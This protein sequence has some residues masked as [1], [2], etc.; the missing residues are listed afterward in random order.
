MKLKIFS[1]AAL[2]C[3]LHICA[4]AAVAKFGGRVVDAQTKNGLAGATVSIPDLH[5][6]VITNN[7]GEFKIANIKREGR[8]L[9]EVSYI[10][11]QTLT[12][13]IDLS[14]TTSIDFVLT[15]SILEG[16]E[17]VV[18]GT[19]FSSDIK[20]NSSSVAI[21]SRDEFTSK[22]ANNFIDALSGI[23][24]VSQITT[25]TAVSKPVIR[26]LS[27]NRVVT[28]ANGV[29]QEGSQF[30][31]EHGIEIDQYTPGRVELIRGPASLLYGSDALA[32]VINLV[33]PVQVPDEEGRMHGEF[34]TN[35]NTNNG[36]WG[37]SLMFLE[38]QNGFIYRAGGT[39][40][41]A[42]SFKTPT[43][44]Y[45]NSGSNE[46]NFD[47]QAGVN[48]SW[49]Y[50]TLNYTGFYSNIGFYE[51]ALN[52]A[53]QYIDANNNVLTNSDYRS[54][55][56]SYPKQDVRHYKWTLN[57]NIPLLGGRLK[58]TLAYQTNKRREIRNTI[59]SSP[60]LF[61]DLDTYSYD[62]KYYFNDKNGFEPII[63]VAGQ[64]QSADNTST[65]AISTIIPNY[66]SQSVGVFAYL[67]KSWA[68]TT[69]NGGVRW[70]MRSID[71]KAYVNRLGILVYP[72]FDN[73]VSSFNGALGV[74]HEFNKQLSFKANAG[75]A[76]RGPNI[77]ELAS[78]GVHEGAFRYEIGNPNL[79]AEYSYQLDASFTYDAD[80]WNASIGGFANYIKDYIYLVNSGVT[81]TLNDGQEPNT[82]FQY[83]YKQA[84]A[85]LWGTEASLTLH[86]SK[87]IHFENTF[88]YVYAQNRTNSQ[89]LPLIPAAHLRNE[90]RFEPTIAGL[91]KS[92]IAISLD[93]Y[94]NQ[95][96]ID[97]TIPYETTTAGYSLLGARIGTTIL[98]K[99]QQLSLY[100]A[101]KNLLDQKYYDALSRLKP[102]RIDAVNTANAGVFNPGMNITFGLVMPLSIKRW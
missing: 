52:S 43:G 29:K 87:S 17:V 49:G 61:L 33:N 78:N 45:P 54:Y 35:Y 39:Y 60:Y 11:Y 66:D 93:N 64:F 86:P 1:F 69:V 58:T 4:V 102:G 100:V 88:S 82:Y 70:D 28:V 31:D 21:L 74:T 63:G 96:R 13:M 80:S 51:Y 75:T 16:K 12:Q 57:G 76:F 84:N 55:T 32:G 71:G 97:T 7:N 47:L 98:L 91:K 72:S 68:N 19:A 56:L 73:V 8:V 25:G 37:S 101:A 46:L 30:G 2:F 24:G 18:T 99:R 41:T 22:P 27:Y 5:I 9:V 67:K 90:L 59:S 6:S 15:P 95:N 85:F 65:R 50:L 44:Y 92:Y 34:L 48:K 40:K 62:V 26:G 14:N 79:K 42:H 36:L 83:N 81:T 3:M 53:G 94:F 23:P 77:S 20:K 89:P 10:G 38:N